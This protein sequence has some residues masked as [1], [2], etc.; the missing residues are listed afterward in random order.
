MCDA[1]AIGLCLNYWLVVFS[2]VLGAQAAYIDILV[3]FQQTSFTFL[4]GVLHEISPLYVPIFPDSIQCFHTALWYFK[5]RLCTILP[6]TEKSLSDTEVKMTFKKQLQSCSE[7]VVLLLKLFMLFRWFVHAAL[8]SNISYD[9][10]SY[11]THCCLRH[12]PGKCDEHT[13][14]FFIP[15]CG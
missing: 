3:W 9:S 12:S 1:C 11:L 4:K 15:W 13:W 2:Q 6:F 8:W 14:K 5:A 7:F 10:I